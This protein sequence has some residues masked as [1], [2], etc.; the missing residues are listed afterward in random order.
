MVIKTRKQRNHPEKTQDIDI[1]ILRAN[2]N[3]ARQN[4]KCKQT[5]HTKRKTRQKIKRQLQ[6]YKENTRI[7]TK[8]KTH[9]Q[10]LQD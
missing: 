7:Q 1:E 6:N 2:K 3:N 5:N 10:T 4:K 9:K 8:A